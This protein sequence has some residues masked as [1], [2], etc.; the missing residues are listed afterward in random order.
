MTPATARVVLIVA[1]LALLTP[2][3]VA[4]R[5]LANARA[6]RDAAQATYLTTAASVDRVTMLR[7]QQQTIAERKRPAQ[8]VIAR[9]EQALAE[10]GVPSSHFSG[11]RPDADAPVP[12]SQGQRITLRRQSVRISLTRFTVAE[13]GEFLAAWTQAQKLWLPT[14]IELIHV[15][16]EVDP[17][18]YDVTLLVTATYVSDQS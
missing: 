10:A 11:V 16:K 13:L 4:G 17:A 9:V 15:E 2:I 7:A 3:V 12:G 5:W 8:D 18:R 1:T 14:R 6:D